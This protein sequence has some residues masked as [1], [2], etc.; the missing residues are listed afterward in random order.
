MSEYDDIIDLPHPQSKT[1]RHMPI[2]DRAAQFASF[3]ALTGHSAAIRETARLTDRKLELS[4]DAAEEL[5]RTLQRLIEIANPK[6]SVTYFVPDERKQGGAY[7]TE[8]VVLK[9][10]EPV[11]GNLECMD[12]KV[13]AVADVTE[14]QILDTEDGME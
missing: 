7:V 11:Y 2:S 3:A 9:R 6:L 14:L 4:E 8:T 1:R 13:I 10:I 12:G 5:N